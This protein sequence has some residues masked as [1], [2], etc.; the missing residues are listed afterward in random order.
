MLLLLHP[1]VADVSSAPRISRVL[2]NVAAGNIQCRPP[3]FR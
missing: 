3:S 2:K 1:G